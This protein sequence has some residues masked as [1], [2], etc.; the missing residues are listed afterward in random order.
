MVTVFGLR[1]RHRS[2][3]FLWPP[4]VAGLIPL[5]N[6]IDR[7]EL[8]NHWENSCR[9]WIIRYRASTPGISLLPSHVSS[10]WWTSEV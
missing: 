8:W 6:W 7:C 2:R 5:S 10:S 4:A 1:Q 9:F 3:Q